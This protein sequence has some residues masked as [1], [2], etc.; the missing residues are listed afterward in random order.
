LI[1]WCGGRGEKIKTKETFEGGENNN[2]TLL[3][4]KRCEEKVNM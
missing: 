2:N 1:E 3:K 4:K